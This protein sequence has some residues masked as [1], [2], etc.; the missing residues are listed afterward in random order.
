MRAWRCEWWCAERMGFSNM[1]SINQP[2]RRQKILE[3]VCIRSGHR[4][5]QLRFGYR[6]TSLTMTARLRETQC[7]PFGYT[8]ILLASPVFSRSIPFEKSLRAMRSVIT[9]RKSSLPLFSN[10][11]IWYQV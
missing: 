8:R 9:G 11:V 2:V 10:A 1:D 4:V 7:V 3:F 5:I 6:L